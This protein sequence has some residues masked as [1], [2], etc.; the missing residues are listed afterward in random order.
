[1]GLKIETDGK[2]VTVYRKDRDTQNGGKFTT[3]SIGIASKDKDGN[4]VNGFID[5]QFKKGVELNNKAKIE[6]ANSFY[7]VSE[8]N[9]KK[10]TKLFVLDFTVVDQG[11]VPQPAPAPNGDGFMNIPTGIEVE[12]PFN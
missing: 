12:L 7:T 10:Y 5:C 1:M 2:A 4:W 11:E 6:I 8:Y 9:G 3:Y